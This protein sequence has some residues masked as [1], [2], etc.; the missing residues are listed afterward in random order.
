M[1]FIRYIPNMQNKLSFEFCEHT[2]VGIFCLSQ[3]LKKTSHFIFRKCTLKVTHF[4]Y[5]AGQTCNVSKY[6]PNT[7]YPFLPF[8]FAVSFFALK[9][10]GNVTHLKRNRKGIKARFSKEKHTHTHTHSLTHTHTHAHTHT[11]TNILT[12]F[13]FTKTL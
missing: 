4:L 6:Y 1:Q 9:S 12:I 8:Y 11:H 2:K 13:C 3:G 5:V 10:F 7:R